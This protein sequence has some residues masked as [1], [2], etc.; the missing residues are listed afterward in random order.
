MAAAPVASG[1]ANAQDAPARAT[2]AIRSDSGSTV[3]WR[4]AHAPRAWRAPHPSVIGALRWRPTATHGAA[5]TELSLEAGGEARFTRVIIVRLDPARVRFELVPR[6]RGGIADW[7][8]D[9]APSDAIIALNAGQ[10]TGSLPWGWLVVNESE[11]LAP[12]VGP[13]SSALVVRR[14]GGIEWIDGDTLDARRARRDIALAFQSYPSLLVGD[15]DVP[16]L[17]HTDAAASAMPRPRREADVDRSHRD[18][19]LALGIDRDGHLLIA[20]TRFDG[21]GGILD[22]I[23]FGPTVPEMSALMG[24]LGAR[25][26]ML[27][28][29]GISAQ[30]L[31]RTPEGT[32]RFAGTRKVPLALVVKGRDRTAGGERRWQRAEGR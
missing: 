21:F 11:R 26:A 10:F 4:A 23:P 15:G 5:W 16:A 30:M 17:L 8:L 29:G 31:I 32:Q 1:R 6:T 18:A 22:R 7:S 3:F 14:D 19:R 28:D 13:L 27:L 20:L 24:A 9:D 12:G 2:L 25:Q